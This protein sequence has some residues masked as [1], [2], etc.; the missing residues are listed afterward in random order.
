[1]PGRRSAW[2]APTSSTRQPKMK[3]TQVSATRFLLLPPLLVL[4]GAP[5]F[6]LESAKP[7]EDP[8][9][10]AQPALDALR[11]SPSDYLFVAANTRKLVVHYDG[12]DGAFVW[13]RVTSFGSWWCDLSPVEQASG[14]V[15]EAQH[16]DDFAACLSVGDV[17]SESRA[18]ERQALYLE[19]VGETVLAARYRAIKGRH[20]WATGYLKAG[21]SAT[22]IRRGGS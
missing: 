1:M 17:A 5:P 7:G 6:P 11:R 3:G 20:G 14:L 13:W 9:A 22:L 4:L 2:K 18:L 16:H 12:F 21:C 19:G 8:I 10:C 15:H